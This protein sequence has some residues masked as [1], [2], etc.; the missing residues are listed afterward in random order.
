MQCQG[1]FYDDDLIVH[2]AERSGAA[3]LRVDIESEMALYHHL[4]VPYDVDNYNVVGGTAAVEYA[5]NLKFS[6]RLSRRDPMLWGHHNRSFLTTYNTEFWG[7]GNC[8]RYDLIFESVFDRTLHG[9]DST[10]SLSL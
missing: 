5:E 2:R 4:D 9:I 8:H 1:Y 6:I 7:G 3:R 10:H